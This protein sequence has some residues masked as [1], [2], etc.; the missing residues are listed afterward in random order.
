MV[1]EQPDCACSSWTSL[2][3]AKVYT[4]YC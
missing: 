1:I 2:F 4:S 3:I